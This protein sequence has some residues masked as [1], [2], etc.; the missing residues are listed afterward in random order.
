MGKQKRHF[1]TSNLTK[2][3][4]CNHKHKTYVNTSNV[5]NSLSYTPQGYCC[6]CMFVASLVKQIQ[7]VWRHGQSTLRRHQRSPQYSLA[8]ISVTIKLLDIGVFGYIGIV[9]PKEHSPEVRSFP[10]GT[11][12]MYLMSANLQYPVPLYLSKCTICSSSKQMKPHIPDHFTSQSPT[13]E[14]NTWCHLQY[15]QLRIRLACDSHWHVLWQYTFFI[16]LYVSYTMYPYAG[17]RCTYACLYLVTQFEIQEYPRVYKWSKS[18]HWSLCTCFCM[19]F[20]F[21]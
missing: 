4:S 8:N 12:C 15:M 13:H 18:I 6:N 16:F 7:G 19:G 10:P 3:L 17:F 14:H 20:Y 5:L 21:S 9:W 2:S 11:P 1:S